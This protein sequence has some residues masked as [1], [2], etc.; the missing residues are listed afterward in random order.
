METSESNFTNARITV[1][2]AGR[3]WP[4]PKLG[5]RQNRIVV[6]ALLELIPKI[7]LAIEVANESTEKRSIC[8]VVSCCLDSKSYDTITKLVFTALTRAHPELTRESFDDMAIDTYELVNAIP[9]IARASG[10]LGWD[11]HYA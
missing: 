9:P 6:P 7:L 2:L 10:L 8:T 11:R 4:I 3:E 5:P 1:V